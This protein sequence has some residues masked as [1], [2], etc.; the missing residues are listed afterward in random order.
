MVNISAPREAEKVRSFTRAG[1]NPGAQVSGASTRF[2]EPAAMSAALCQLIRKHSWDADC[3]PSGWFAAG[4]I[5]HFCIVRRPA[6]AAW[7]RAS[8]A[9]A[10]D[11][12]LPRWRSGARPW[13]SC[14]AGA[15]G[16]P[17]QSHFPAQPLGDLVEHRFADCECADRVRN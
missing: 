2:V 5:R 11:V 14:R 3:R 12:P 8:V 1:P 16:A 6:L 9:P 7:T 13:S 10:T 15:R 4:L 17:G